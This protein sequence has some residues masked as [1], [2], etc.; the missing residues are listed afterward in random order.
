VSFAAR[1]E[2]AE[3]WEHEV[4]AAL[5]AR[6][7][8]VEPYGQ[9]LLTEAARRM[10]RLDPHAQHRWLPDLLAH[11]PDKAVS[12]LVDAK[13]GDGPNYAI[14][15]SALAA[16]VAHEANALM[17]LYIVFHDWHVA[18]ACELWEIVD[19]ERIARTGVYQGRGS[20]TPFWVIKKG[21]LPRTFDSTFGSV[22]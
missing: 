9:A 15:K 18:R 11:H 12:V 2:L 7:W 16:L 21:N 19:D 1:L 4:A 6:G 3:A 14:E 13:T 17:P 10:L 22:Q 8:A 20:G 5:E